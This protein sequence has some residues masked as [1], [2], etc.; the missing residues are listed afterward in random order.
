MQKQFS[1]LAA[2]VI[3]G[4]FNHPHM[5]RASPRGVGDH[6]LVL[7]CLICCVT[8][9][10]IP[11][12]LFAET[13]VLDAAVLDSRTV[14]II[15]THCGSCHGGESS[16]GDINFDAYKSIEEAREHIDVW[17]KVRKV[18]DSHQ[19]P[20]PDARQPDDLDLKR[21]QSWTHAFLKAEAIA[22]AGDPGP[23]L[24]RRLSNAE[25]DYAIRD[26]TGV[27]EL[28]PSRDLPV[29]G[30]AG[31]GFTNVGSG[32]AMSPSLIRK[33][34]DSAKRVAE[35]VVLLP[36]GIEFSSS[37]TQRDRTNK[38]L[39]DIRAFY[40]RYTR[41][42]GGSTI[43]LHGLKFE[44]NQGGLLP[45]KQ[46]LRALLERRD[47]LKSG[48]TTIEEVAEQFHLNPRYLKTISKT[49]L[50]KKSES[51]LV[52]QLRLISN[53]TA[54]T[55]VDSL[56]NHVQQSQQGFWKF[57]SIGHIGRE[58]GPQ[59]WMD[60]VV[61][62]FDHQ[63][64]RLSLPAAGDQKDI[65]VSLTTHDL[66]DGDEQDYVVWS[67]PHLLMN[68]STEADSSSIMLRDVKAVS[69]KIRSMQRRELER[70]Q[71]YL[72]AIL[73]HSKLSKSHAPL[74]VNEGG[75]D[76]EL[77]PA[78]VVNWANFLGL[79]NNV[80]LQI[81][82][83][84][85][86]SLAKVRGHE[87]VNGWGS[88]ATPSLL[89]N[90]SDKSISFLTLTIPERSVVMHPS[91]TSAAVVAWK[92]PMAGTIRVKSAVAD[93]DHK[94]GNGAV[95]KIEHR[96][97]LGTS[98]V[99]QGV[100]NNG[101]R[102]E[103]SSVQPLKLA[104]G[105]VVALMVLP[106]DKNHSCD[107]THVELE[108]LEV[109][110]E[111]RKWVLSEQVVDR[112]QEG[113]PLADTFGNQDV[114]HFG[115]SVP[116]STTQLP[117]SSVLSRWRKQVVAL[118]GMPDSVKKRE[119]AQLANEVTHVLTTGDPEGLASADQE[120]RT[121]ALDWHGPLR[122]LNLGQLA[123]TADKRESSDDKNPMAFGLHPDGSTLMPNDLCRRGT[124]SIQFHI[125][126]ELAATEF[127]T[128]VKLHSGDGVEGSVQVQVHV[129]SVEKPVLD[130][131]GP[132]LVHPEGVIGESVRSAVHSFGSLFPPMLCYSSIVPVDEVV[133]LRLFHREDDH[134]RRLML[135]SVEAHELDRLWDE[136]R[137]VSDAPI[138]QAV[139]FEQIAEFATQDRP[140]LVIAFEPLRV[141]INHQATEFK[142]Q[143]I[144]L[145]PL[146]VAAVVN[147]AERA[148]RRQIGPTSKQRMIALY[149]H[150]RNEGVQHREAVQTLI[151]H[152][153]TAPDFLYK[154]ETPQV[155]TGQSNVEGEELAARLSFFLWSSIPDSQLLELGRR[156]ALKE[157]KVMVEQME[158]MLKD[159]RAKRLASQF[160]CQWLHLRDFD[161]NDDKNEKLYPQFAALR[162]S[163]YGET[164]RF[165]ENM[166][167]NNGSLLDVIDSDHTFLDE[168]LAHHYGF[169]W[170]TDPDDSTEISG[171][172][173]WR[174]FEGIRLKGRGGVLGMAAFL[175]SQSGA[176][177]TSPILRGNW[178]YE[179]LLGEQ[180]PRPPVDV[181]LLPEQVPEGLT[182]RQLIEKHSSVVACAKCHAHI[183]P[184]GFA[185]EG[186]DAL[187]G[188]RE[189]DGDTTATLLDGQVI[190]GADGLR[191]YLLQDRRGDVVRQF[192]RKLLG[193]AL[194]REV[195]LSD[196]PLLDHMQQ[197]LS[198]GDFKVEIAIEMIINSRQ[199]C[200]IRDQQTKLKTPTMLKKTV[201]KKTVQP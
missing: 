83:L 194:G 120:L 28:D 188:K 110:G 104:V 108:V 173:H 89:T 115:K 186:Y 160:A 159:P 158:R 81:K 12:R 63:E 168:A 109:A 163:M 171:D 78:L 153:L 25:Y 105:D 1:L 64:L 145:E 121:L 148:W 128:N 5:R 100:I 146:Q 119:V 182:S 79:G 10:Y 3:V 114:W 34:L 97:R 137:F 150:L 76:I 192:C 99:A 181:P 50:E 172:S 16:E 90:R 149:Q 152:V 85:K 107:M 166:F 6:V 200:Q 86:N 69:G 176:S 106:R 53:A 22:K 47:A 30:A 117:V 61:P 15:K 141:P 122:W 144:A 170:N 2:T 195:L 138:K 178:I 103:W 94:C 167:Q 48:S 101:G 38:K 59:R 77:N 183:D 162:R 80:D 74:A 180:L 142:K 55:D 20:P 7:F 136:L 21:L 84:F 111:Q 102:E 190:T 147:W 65:Q 56:L 143:K 98:L 131:G 8:V 154:L 127:V 179:T 133:T 33:Y 82:G 73:D 29:D 125:P 60:Q 49:L 196:E 93:A 129:G 9:S 155:G 95:W 161:Q 52:R 23:V 112:V 113:N 140:D 88:E 193:Y 44:G 24:L 35:H 19:M 187:G 87:S 134:L 116:R 177:R 201:P 58:G 118:A 75:A 135:D 57:N 165:F 123:V 36:T 197:A 92:S 130:F 139:A 184:F 175:A 32:Q 70:T 151:A 51:F 198:V 67:E 40:Q 37:T 31:E 43:N 17:L 185:L 68:T 191:H 71:R 189:S 27:S 13:V 126:R 66:G 14:S 62:V 26:L 72:S 11:E 124:S 41:T 4:A 157:Q 91:P 96:S 164:L 199:F 156:G 42:G 169:H 46:Y 18:L 45:I 39:S 174:K 54:V 132:F